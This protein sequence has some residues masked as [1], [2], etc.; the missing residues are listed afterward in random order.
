MALSVNFWDEVALPVRRLNLRHLPC[1]DGTFCQFLVLL[2]H[3]R[4]LLVHL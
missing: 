3:S 1:I 2:R 4:P